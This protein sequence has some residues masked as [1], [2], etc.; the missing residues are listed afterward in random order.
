MNTLTFSFEVLISYMN[1]EI[2]RTDLKIKN[3]KEFN[4]DYQL[5]NENLVPALLSLKFL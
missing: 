3:C 2:K 4:S 1:T 5:Y